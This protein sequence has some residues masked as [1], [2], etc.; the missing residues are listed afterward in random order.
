MKNA[1]WSTF[2]SLTVAAVLV[3]FAARPPA[4]A[5]EAAPAAA[6]PPALPAAELPA[7]SEVLA[8]GPVHEAFAKPVLLDP[9]APIIVPK[10][11][12]ANL[13]E[14]PPE[15]KPAGA[16][17][18]WV[19]G[20]WAWDADRDDFIW[21]SGCWRNAPPN[22]YWVPGH[23]LQAGD[24]WEWLGGF[25]KPIVAQPQQEIEYLPAPPAT[26]EVDPPGAPPQPDQ[27]WVPGCWYWVGG[28]YVQRAGY[29]LTQQAGW[30]WV[31][32]HYAWTPRGYIFCPGHW[33]YDLDNRGVL[34]SPAY[35]PPAARGVGGFI[36]CP[37]ICV[38]LGLLRLDLFVYPRYRHYCFGDY[39]DDAY[40]GAGI[41]P[42]FQCQT[43][44]TW[45]DPL[46]IH[47]R[48]HFGR[49]EPHWAEN[50]EHEFAK[51]R[52]D[53]DLRPVR[54]FAE[55]QA[56]LARAPAAGRPAHP[57]L[58]TVKT[59]ATSPVTATKFERLTAAERQQIAVKSTAVHQ[60]RDQ[61]GHWEGPTAAGLP[62][63]DH[64]PAPKPKPAPEPAPNRPVAPPST[65]PAWEA[66][67]P[68]L[69]P[70]REVRVA[71]PEREVVPNLLRTPEPS[72]SRYIANEPPRHPVEER[73]RVESPAGRD[74]GMDSKSRTGDRRN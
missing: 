8:R 18:V 2:S 44:H 34:F 20:Y 24:G 70:P 27:T 17:I 47:D 31:P 11:P 46:F 7:G 58:E 1:R 65:M 9:Q 23:W 61:R 67:A 36:F 54:T 51:R 10:P 22:T 15:E 62:V 39:Y 74:A 50:Q 69:V 66:R 32:S 43:A 21:V 16:A 29:W 30:V 13:E 55:L 48:W 68:A 33:D 45:Y 71:R 37:S 38:D 59:V 57:L 12:P 49:T 35:F 60:L 19:P 72:E 25:W 40:R 52:A 64:G 53:R 26:V 28:Q 14:V 6:N 63:T 3:L 5:Q 42:W 41:Y 4:A 73:S 56:Q